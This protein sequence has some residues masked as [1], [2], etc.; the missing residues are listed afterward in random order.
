MSVAP[1]SVIPGYTLEYSSLY[2]M[3]LFV[4]GTWMYPRVC[5]R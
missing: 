5:M 4:E 3:T 1:L 2:E